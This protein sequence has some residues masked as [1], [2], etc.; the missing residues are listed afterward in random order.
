MAQCDG[1]EG[2]S[3]ERKASNVVLP[4]RKH[5]EMKAGASSFCLFHSSQIPSQGHGASNSQSGSLSLVKISGNTIIDILRG[6]F[7][8]YAKS[9]QVDKADPPSRSLTCGIVR[10]I[11]QVSHVSVAPLT[12]LRSVWMGTHC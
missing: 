5:G 3:Q 8:G 9:T 6:V 10:T 2:R 4:I 7:H 1:G 11:P 12:N